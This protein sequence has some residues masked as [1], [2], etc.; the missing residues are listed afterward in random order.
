MGR[1]VNRNLD[2]LFPVRKYATLTCPEC[3][4]A[5]Y[6]R[7]VTAI[8]MA[9]D[10]Y[11]EGCPECGT[12]FG[13]RD[14][15]RETGCRVCGAVIP[16]DTRLRRYCTRRCRTI[17]NTVQRM[18]TWSAVRERVLDRDDWTCQACGVDVSEDSDADAEV[19]HITPLA[20]GGRPLDESNLI[21]LCGGCHGEKTHG[22]APDTLGVQDGERPRRLAPEAYVG[23]RG[24]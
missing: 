24:E 21:T 16:E 2:E 17:A 22:D 1:N 6:F 20:D 11:R 4:H 18:F 8:R 10:R 5:D 15:T 7:D 12:E 14:V 3:D 9:A 13:P 19:D 23:G